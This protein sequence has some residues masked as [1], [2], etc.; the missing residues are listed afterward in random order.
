MLD[1]HGP[2]R[3]ECC[4]LSVVSLAGTALFLFGMFL[5]VTLGLSVA[6]LPIGLSAIIS[7]L[8]GVRQ[9]RWGYTIWPR[10]A[11]FCAWATV[12]FGLGLIALFVALNR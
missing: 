7:G 10:F 8:V 9:R 5:L 1:A 6:A 2:S 4:L 11:R 3:W 12:I